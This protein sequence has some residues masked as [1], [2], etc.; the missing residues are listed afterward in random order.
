MAGRLMKVCRETHTA[1]LAL[2]PF[3]AGTHIGAAGGIGRNG[4]ETQTGEKIVEAGRVHL[5]RLAS[6]GRFDN[7][8]IS[9]LSRHGEELAANGVP[10]R[11]HEE[12]RLAGGS[13]HGGDSR[14][15]DTFE[16]A[17]D[18]AVGWHVVPSEGGFVGGGGGGRGE[19]VHGIIGDE[20]FGVIWG[21]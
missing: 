2:Q 8:L 5:V 11:L 17:H 21:L 12:V 13:L 3:R 9:Q 19:G 18:L 15:L 6:E 7:H 1:Q 4:G 16:F 10:E 14:E 20:R